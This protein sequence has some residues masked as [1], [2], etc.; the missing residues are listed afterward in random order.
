RWRLDRA[1]VVDRAVE[2]SRPLVDARGQR[3]AVHLPR[4]PV[5]VHGDLTR[6]A[7]VVINLLNNASKFTPRGG[8]IHLTLDVD[9]SQALLRVR[10]NGA[11]IT[12]ELMPRI[13]DI[14]TQG[15]A[16]LD[17]SGGGLAIALTL[18]R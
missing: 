15:D 14:F 12:S 18:R 8:E 9:A 7:Q 17:R 10:D 6:L 5:R 11:G 2:S 13:F 16:E 3:L 1:V 4:D